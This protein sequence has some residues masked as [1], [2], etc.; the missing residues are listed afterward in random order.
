MN[1]GTFTLQDHD[2]ADEIPHLLHSSRKLCGSCEGGG[3]MV[4]GGGGVSGNRRMMPNLFKLILCV[5]I[6]VVLAK[7]AYVN[8]V[9]FN[10]GCF[11]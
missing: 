9:C 8:I 11:S 5:W 10:F 6:S 4:G 3:V 1:S 2:D 7:F